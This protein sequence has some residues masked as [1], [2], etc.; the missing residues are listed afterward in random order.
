MMPESLAT[1]TVT[2]IT[3]A[4]CYSHHTRLLL[5]L[6][7]SHTPWVGTVGS[8]MLHGLSLCSYHY[9]IAVFITCLSLCLS[10]LNSTAAEGG[11]RQPLALVPP[12]VTGDGAGMRRRGGKGRRG[13]GRGGEEGKG[14]GRDGEWARMAR[15]ESG[16]P[17]DAR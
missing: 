16:G 6:S 10:L 5:Q 4:Y 2:A 7:E 8:L 15:D 17:K 9:Q 13:E 3:H 14:A 12:H 1:A 11:R